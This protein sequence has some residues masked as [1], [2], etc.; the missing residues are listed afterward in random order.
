[1][2]NKQKKEKKVDVKKSV[3]SIVFMVFVIL[4]SSYLLQGC[5]GSIIDETNSESIDQIVDEF[6]KTD[7]QDELINQIEDD[8]V[9]IADSD[10]EEEIEY[11][12]FDVVESIKESLFSLVIENNNNSLIPNSLE[13]IEFSEDRMFGWVNLSGFELSVD[14]GFYYFEVED[15]KFIISNDDYSF[16]AIIDF[17]YCY[18]VDTKR[19]STIVINNNNYSCYFN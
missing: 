9:E 2:N 11:I 10:N 8:A 12:E 16:E 1:M 3:I 5:D 14:N 19:F 7:N 6:L 17:D 4:S 15:N 13:I 18:F